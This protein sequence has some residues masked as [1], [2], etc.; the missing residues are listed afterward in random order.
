MNAA[1]EPT[2]FAVGGEG[3]G[4]SG[5]AMFDMDETITAISLGDT[6]DDHW[7]ADAQLRTEGNELRKLYLPFGDEIARLPFGPA[8]SHANKRPFPASWREWGDGAAYSEV[9]NKMK[10][11]YLARNNGE[12]FEAIKNLV[13]TGRH[14]DPH[15]PE[16]LSV[17]TE[18]E[19]NIQ[20]LA[21]L[22]DALKKTHHLVVISINGTAVTN[23]FIRQV[24]PGVFDEV[25][26]WEDLIDA[27][28]DAVEKKVSKVKEVICRYEQELGAGG[29]HIFVDDGSRY[30]APVA[31]C[32]VQP[33][34][35]RTEKVRC[36][37][38]PAFEENNKS[39]ERW[40]GAFQGGKV[41]LGGLAADPDMIAAILA[42][43][44]ADAAAP[45][46]FGERTGE[47][48]QQAA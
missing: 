45:S 34:L 1:M 2:V 20:S 31:E 24:F 36:P 5:V 28:T 3:K 11:K 13:M 27:T 14:F 8:L 7:W 30:M 17:K 25:I 40:S 29:R 39:G 38:V 46:Y 32:G 41:K 43:A 47:Q 9:N 21:N 12:N 16:C 10:F 18:A 42:H 22:F 15:R 33:V 26:G 4:A 37:I 23:S 48:L 44:A 6:L 19:A 35:V